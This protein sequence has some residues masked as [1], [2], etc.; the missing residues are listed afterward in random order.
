MTAVQERLSAAL[1][2]RY[3]IE[4]ELGQGGMATVYLAQDVKHD[5]KVA[6]KVLK[7]ELAAVLG[8]ER[9]VVEIKTTAALQHPHILPL[10]DSG[11]ADGFLFYVMPF[12]AGETLRNKL[13]RETQFGVEEAVKIASEVADALH[14]AHSQGVIHRDIKPENILLANGRPMVADFGIAL[15]LSA[16]A[17]GRM[18]ETG[19]SLGTPHYM[20]PEQATADKEITGRSD[21]YSLASVLYEMLT[22]NPPYTGSSA[23]QI[24]MKIVTEEAAPVTKLRKSVPPNVAAAVAKALE[25]LPADR[26]ASAKE[27]ADA[28]GDR[29]F[30]S[31]STTLGS[32]AAGPPRSW[33]SWLRDPRSQSALLAVAAL[34]AVSLFARTVPAVRSLGPETLRFT[35]GGPADSSVLSMSVR[36]GS[37]LAHPAMSVDGRHVAFSVN[38]SAG[39]ALFVRA[40]D[41]FELFEVP[42][43]GYWPFFSPDGTAIGFFR[44]TELWTMSLAER[45]P[46]RV[47]SFAERPWDITSATWHP[48]GRILVT[49]ARGL[50]V[51]AARGGEPA[52]LVAT[53]SAGR[54]K[55]DEVGVLDDGRLVLS[56][57][58]RDGAR[59]EVVSRDGAERRRIVPG[60]ERVRIVDDVMFFAQAGQPRATRF[61][62]R[63]LVPEGAPI[64][65]AEFPS[66]RP[67][68]SIAW[69][70]GAGVRDLE[71]VWVS[72]T[73]AVTPVGLPGAQY[74][75]PRVSPDGRRLVFGSGTG[76]AAGL[77]A[78]DLARRTTTRLGGTTE[79]V[80]SADGRHVFASSGNRPLGGIV[81]QLGDG[82]RAPDTLLSVE[83]GDAWPT[84]VSPDGRWLAFYGATLG[85]GEGDAASDPNDLTFLELT[86]RDIRR[87]RLGGAQR[88]ARFS[89]D[90]R[91]VAYESTESGREE[92]H[93]RPWPSMDANFLVSGGG[94]NEPTWSPDGREIY[95][96]RGTEMLA[97]AITRRGAG[98]D[99]APPRVLFTGVFHR[100]PWGDQS[101]DVAPDGR[102]LMMRPLPGGRV[103]LR[104]ALNWIADVQARLD[105][106][107]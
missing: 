49:G 79:P 27:F 45:V 102:F 99:R 21:I 25:K 52:L 29:Q 92:V 56:I 76:S 75:W 100:D 83:T 59:T 1:S 23:Q 42:G 81:I 51:V 48:D 89:P 107:R 32:A 31:A 96:R 103:E 34:T 28:L 6:L 58:A 54:E 11:T 39:P 80:W 78:F 84:A 30:T 77:N 93:L 33:R 106:A 63:D 19:L 38:R 35:V 4:R 14:Y 86:R 69:V 67:G 72:R 40:L 43:E 57:S 44:D 71:P 36:A 17:G 13:D 64:A 62:A 50:W 7:S 88:G 101:Y 90:G 85:V 61:D 41:S 65:L 8:A 60:F 46:S 104:V 95:Y 105:R 47:G 74:R 9:F 73:G 97:V 10:F 98:L 66:L 22:G 70:D 94:G 68:R 24:I 53:D 2:D 20:S 82:S 26:F 16:A 37:P 55:F 87:I 91:W 15:A 5:R 3:R 18:T 12:I